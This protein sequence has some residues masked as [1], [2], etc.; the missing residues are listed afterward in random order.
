M[1]TKNYGIR[2]CDKRD[3]NTHANVNDVG[4]KLIEGYSIDHDFIKDGPDHKHHTIYG[5][6]VGMTDYHINERMK[7]LNCESVKRIKQN[8]AD[9]LS[10]LSADTNNL[11]KNQ[12]STSDSDISFIPL[13]YS[14]YSNKQTVF[15]QPRWPLKGPPL[16]PPPQPL[17]L[18]QQPQ[19][20]QPPQLQPQPQPQPQPQQS[21]L[22]TLWNAHKLKLLGI[23]AILIF[24]I[25]IVLIMRWYIKDDRSKLPNINVNIET[26]SDKTTRIRI[27]KIFGKKNNYKKLKN[28]NI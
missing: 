20:P 9:I 13:D 14:Q 17:Q 26:P 18:P 5:K 7:R 27:Q 1:N 12:E 6:Y 28:I 8:Q 19:P 16:P 4:K 23:F 2:G 24:I 10:V 21:F 11:I 22:T 15:Q 3:D 25:I